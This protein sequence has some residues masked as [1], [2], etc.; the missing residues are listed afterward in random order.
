MNQVECP[1]N[2]RCRSGGLQE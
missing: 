1:Q 2:K